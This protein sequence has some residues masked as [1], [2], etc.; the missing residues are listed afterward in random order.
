MPRDPQFLRLAFYPASIK[1]FRCPLLCLRTART[2]CGHHDHHFHHHA[3]C[4]WL[5]ATPWPIFAPIVRRGAVVVPICSPSL[6][7]KKAHP[8]Q[9]LAVPCQRA[10]R[11]WCQHAEYFYPPFQ[12]HLPLSF[13]RWAVSTPGRGYSI[14]CARCC[15]ILPY[16]SSI[17][18]SSRYTVAALWLTDPPS[19]SCRRLLQWTPPSPLLRQAPSSAPP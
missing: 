17:V 8:Q 11:C 5:Q 6:V 12:R 4:Q 19:S 2:R 16:S 3:R 9:S 18:P 14:R 1:R 13:K 15:S 10:P 7:P